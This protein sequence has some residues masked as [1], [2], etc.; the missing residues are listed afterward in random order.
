MSEPLWTVL[1][2]PHGSGQSRSVVVSRPALRIVLGSVLAIPLT[3][4]VLAFTTVSK[5]VDFARLERLDRQNRFLAEQLQHTRQMVAELNDT[6]TIIVKRNQ[7]VRLLAG[8][9]P[10]DPEVQL[11][12]IGGPRPRSETGELAEEPMGQS[13]LVARADIS[14]LL[15]RASLL[16]QSYDEAIDSLSAHREM[17][18]R[19]PSIWPTVGFLSSAFMASRI[20]PIHQ[21][22]RPHEGVDVSAPMGAPISAPAGGLVIDIGNNEPGYGKIVTIDHG[23][24]IVTRY[25]HCS[26]INVRVG[27][28]VKRGEVIALV[29]KTGI[30][31]GPHLHYEVIVGGKHVDPRTYILPETIVD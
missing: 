18:Q 16:A 24:N 29:G 26:R 2:V 27:Q 19:M 31:T 11:A 25:A 5:S 7:Q 9:E 23:Y 14:T 15:R 30:S 1:V 3:A 4:I 12:G 17:L 22:A 6:M 28:R 13:A 10:T 8:L 20:H 21:Y